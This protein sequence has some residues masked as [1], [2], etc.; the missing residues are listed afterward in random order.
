MT[1]PL[2]KLRRLAPRATRVAERRKSDAPSLG[3]F[4]A[5]VVTKAGAF[6]TAYD[7]LVRYEAPWRREI[8]EGK[9]AAAALHKQMRS[10][11]P[12][13]LRDVPGFLAG[14]FGDQPEV[15]DDLIADG[16]R[17]VDVIEAATTRGGEALPYRDIA[18]AALDPLVAT[19][20]KEWQEAEAADRHYQ[21]LG[22]A[23]RA[24]AADFQTELVLFRRTLMS[25]AGRSDRD[26]QKLR[27]EKAITA[28]ED[29]DPNAPP[30]PEPVAPGP[31]PVGS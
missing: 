11:L 23:T 19:A 15:P 3:V 31:P 28:D 12:A 13:L 7:S 25:V 1:T 27:A 10:W 14:D 4:A 17:L 8:A 16:E 21:S 6:T 5:S 29:D 2:W 20:Q 18:V 26:Y 30:V 9:S 22:A 24:T